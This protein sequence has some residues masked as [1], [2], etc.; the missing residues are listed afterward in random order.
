M[1][2]TSNILPVTKE[3]TIT[4]HS[5]NGVTSVPKTEIYRCPAGKKAKIELLFY[6]SSTTN[7]LTLELCDD[8]TQESLG[9]N[10]STIVYSYNEFKSGW[11]ILTGSATVQPSGDGYIPVNNTGKWVKRFLPIQEG[12][13]VKYQVSTSNPWRIIYN[14]IEEDI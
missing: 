7:N 13:Y 8:L 10:V 11:S 9:N 6:R 5:L 12:Q 4:Q 14:I 1:S 3:E 2:L